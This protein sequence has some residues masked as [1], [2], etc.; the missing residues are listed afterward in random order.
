MLAL[1]GL[2]GLAIAVLF[3]SLVLIVAAWPEGVEYILTVRFLRSAWLASVVGSILTVVFL[4]SQATGRSIGSSLS[5]GAWMDL[6][7]FTP[8]V[9]A[10]RATPRNSSPMV[11]LSRALRQGNSASP[12]NRRG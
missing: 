3:G 7:E 9:A 6:K 10:L 5:P 1:L 12:W 8:G 11:T 4:T 2:L